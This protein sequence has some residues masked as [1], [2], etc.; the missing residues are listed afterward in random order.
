[1]I[2]S[3]GNENTFDLEI[4]IMANA[5]LIIIPQ[6]TISID[7]AFVTNEHIER[8]AKPL[9]LVNF[10]Y[11]S[12]PI[13]MKLAIQNTAVINKIRNQVENGRSIFDRYDSTSNNKTA[14]MSRHFAP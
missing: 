8:N 5:I 1:M 2:R 9:L 7:A 6:D 12:S 4:P 14:N 10:P 13:M 11:L 3:I